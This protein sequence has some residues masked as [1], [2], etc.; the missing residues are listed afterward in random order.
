MQEN[1]GAVTVEVEVEVPINS[2]SV[3]LPLLVYA[4]TATLDA[5]QFSGRPTA[6]SSSSGNV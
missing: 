4:F 3:C 5:V 1:S 2:P 6:Y